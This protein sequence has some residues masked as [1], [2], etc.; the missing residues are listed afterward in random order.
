MRAAAAVGATV[1]IAAWLAAPAFGGEGFVQG[2]Y[3]LGS[4]AAA[5]AMWV[6]IHVRRPRTVR[7]WYWLAWAI[8]AWAAADVVYAAYGWFGHPDPQTSLA[9]VLYLLGYAAVVVGLVQVIRARK[10]EGD[11]DALLDATAVG[12][13]ALLLAWDLLIRPTIDPASTLLANATLAIYPAADVLVLALLVRLLL[14]T[15][16][17]SAATIMLAT[18]LG[19]WLLADAA[20]SVLAATDSYSFGG[21][22][23]LDQVWLF[24]MFLM[25]G[26]ALHPDMA[27]LTDDRAEP[28]VA[29]PYRLAVGVTCVT[30]PGLTMAIADLTD[31]PAS[32]FAFLVATLLLAALVLARSIRLLRQKDA[33]E[34]ALRSSDR[35]HRLLAENSA[36]AVL[37]TDATGVV[38]AE[39]PALLELLGYDATSTRGESIFTLIAPDDQAAAAALLDRALSRPGQ[40]LTGELRVAHA[41][42]SVRW[43]EVRAVSL[44]D[45][46]DVR[47]VVVNIHDIT[48][49]KHM[50]QELSH[51]AFHDTL[52]GLANRALFRDRIEH[53][54]QR[55][56]RTG[57][58]A[59][60]L[61]LDLD[62]FKT[63]NDCL[64]H[65]TGD[66][67]L[68]VI[69]ERLLA[70]VRS[71][72]TVARLGGDEF[73]VLVEPGEDASTRAEA[74]ATRILAAL[75]EPVD[76]GGTRLSV[77]ASIGVAIG[78]ADSEALLRN[79]DV[80]M[81]QAKAAGKR[82]WV[83][84]DDGMRAAAVE[85]LRIDTDLHSVLERDELA[86]HYQPIVELATG[87][88]T[89]FEALL[90]WNHPSL[91]LLSPDRFIPVAED[92]GTIVAIGGWV[93]A[94]A[95]ATAREWQ[96]RHADGD[97]LTMSVNLSPRQLASTGVVDMV[98][99]AL[100]DSGVPPESVVL[101]L[102]ESYLVHDPDS[103]T[104]RLH[105]LRDL[106]VRLAVDDFG[107]GYSSLGYLRQFP[108]D[109]LKIDRSFVHALT[110]DDEVPGLIRAVLDLC[111]TLD[112]DAVAEG[113]EQPHQLDQLV[114]E[115]CRLGQGFLFDRPL[116]FEAA[117]ALVGGVD[118]AGVKPAEAR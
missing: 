27:A 55:T 103:A 46:P 113:I 12:V 115:R 76:V 15:R 109:I 108:V 77:G 82:R 75:A 23:W 59:A 94:T 13:A 48:I 34:A 18:A 86:L 8:S 35:F 93:M 80:A 91:G 118:V 99:E 19:A 96:V 30:V 58:E 52:T 45:D 88:L 61:Y 83:V 36:D 71:E 117:A 98:R 92:N 5:V 110:R 105:E 101:E 112:L 43:V 11:L 41:D 51:Q 84:F 106:G 14:D 26:A 65:D 33:A 24:G 39:A 42:Q 57:D 3:L 6:G 64:G 54:V 63:I 89:G 72:D 2:A 50:E 56:V 69:A 74:V 4:V 60:V 100:A 78:H 31:H 16:L 37:V 20:Y 97:A 10:P 95:C 29:R 28:R 32:A 7:P 79:A 67:V 44:I 104:A 21:T 40:V 25:A 85:R 62:G 87:R 107:T 90:R 9:D 17:R 70:S 1:V 22:A 116:S 38:T 114:S 73:G 81:Y 53:A 102:T 49:R 111:R 66:S 47:G 68:T